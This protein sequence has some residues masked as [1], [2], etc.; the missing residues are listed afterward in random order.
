MIESLIPQAAERLVPGG[1]LLMEVSPT[2]HDAV[3][4]LLESDGRFEL[5]ATIKDLARLPRVVHGM[6]RQDVAK[7]RRT[8]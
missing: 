3:C 6:R 5:A 2:I 4:G 7:N 8:M 1:H